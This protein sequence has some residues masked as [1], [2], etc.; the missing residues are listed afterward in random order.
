[1]PERQGACLAFMGRDRSPICW[2]LAALRYQ[3]SSTLFR[4]TRLQQGRVKMYL[5]F[6]SLRHIELHWN[7]FGK[8]VTLQWSFPLNFSEL[9]TNL[10]YC[11]LLL[12]RNANWFVPLQSITVL[13]NKCI[14]LMCKLM[15]KHAFAVLRDAMCD[16]PRQ[17]LPLIFLEQECLL[18]GAFFIFLMI[19]VPQSLLKTTSLSWAP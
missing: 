3:Q 1:M 18:L 4:Q 7:V 12:K 5:G 6:Y 10:L 17:N 13:H 11:N 14:W 8:T 2:Q 9:V 15:Y 19:F 16:T